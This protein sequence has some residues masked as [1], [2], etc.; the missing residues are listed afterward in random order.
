MKILRLGL[1][2]SLEKLTIYITPE[3]E[4]KYGKENIKNFFDKL[5]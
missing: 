4:K 3:V 1:T 5:N 2:R